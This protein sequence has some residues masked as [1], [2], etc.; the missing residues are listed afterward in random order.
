ML[1]TAHATATDRCRPPFAVAHYRKVVRVSQHAFHP[2]ERVAEMLHKPR[3]CRIP[4]ALL[5]YNESA[6]F[7]YY[8]AGLV[9]YYTGHW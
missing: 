3:F 5:L 2:P 6:F 7:G 1:Q 9:F 8:T 4:D